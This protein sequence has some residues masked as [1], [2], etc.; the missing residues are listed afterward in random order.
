MTFRS[1]AGTSTVD[2]INRVRADGSSS[3]NVDPD[4]RIKAKAQHA[5][6][7]ERY[8]AQLN[9]FFDG[10]RELP[11]HLKDLLATR[12]GAEEHGFAPSEVATDDDEKKKK[13]K[14]KNGKVASEAAP[15]GTR[16]RVASSNGNH[17]ALLD[18]LKKA[19]SPREVESAVNALRGAGY[20][21]PP[22]IDLM[23]KALGHSDEEVIAEAL[24]GLKGLGLSPQV[25]GANLL[26]SRLKNVALIASSSEVRELCGE[27]QTALSG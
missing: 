6:A 2:R 13:A 19:S 16:R 4:E 9:E 14:K 10:K 24:R 27:L 25:K 15:S 23:S 26:K 3:Q 17:G 8:K 5:T 12:P 1:R 20:D 7:Y 18:A 21:L 11:D 22:D